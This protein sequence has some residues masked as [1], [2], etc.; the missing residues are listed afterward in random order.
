MFRVALDTARKAGNVAG[1]GMAWGNLGNVHRALAQFEKAIECHLKYR[2]NAQRRL[3][4]GG[5]AIMQH[6]LAMDYF[7]SGNLPEAEKSIID[8]FQTLESI[9]SQIGKDDQSK[10]SNFEK[11]QADAYNLLQMVLVAQKKYKE[12][13]V[14][15]DASRGRALTEIVR[16]RVWGSISSP[17]D[18]NCLR[19]EFTTQSFQSLL[20]VS[21]KLSTALVMYSLVKEFDRTGAIFSW[22]YAWVLHPTGS[23]DFSKTPLQSGTEFK[24]EVND[25]FIFKLRSSMAQQS[26]REGLSQFIKNTPHLPLDGQ[27]LQPRTNIQSDEVLE[28]LRGLDLFPGFKCES[29]DNGNSFFYNLQWDCPA[30]RKAK[31]E[32]EKGRHDPL[33]SSCNNDLEGNHLG[34]DHIDLNSGETSQK[35]CTTQSDTKAQKG[36]NVAAFLTHGNDAPNSNVTGVSVS[37]DPPPTT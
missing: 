11:N 7:L 36:Q 5:V 18:I 25:E 1:E 8:A 19:E 2:D 33:Q 14:F 20:Q 34:S 10:L 28:S 30:D 12:A 31:S 23:L 26:Q 3:D 4:V 21:R 32:T 16:N 27:Q 22:V 17:T 6:Q 24:V 15:A 13:F 37:T 29:K 9:R 35:S